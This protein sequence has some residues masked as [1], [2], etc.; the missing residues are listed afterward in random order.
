MVIT[1][2]SSYEKLKTALK[3]Y[4]TSHRKEISDYE[5]NR[6]Y[7]KRVLKDPYKQVAKELRLIDVSM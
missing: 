4:Q 5:K 2:S 7:R 6:Q 3:K 1:S